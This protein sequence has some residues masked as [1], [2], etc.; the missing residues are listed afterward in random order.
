MLKKKLI[1]ALKKAG[2][3]EGLADL[4]NITSEDQI[5]GVV[6]QLKQTQNNDESVLDFEKILRSE[7]FENYVQKNGFDKVLGLSKTLQ[8]EHDRKVTKGIATGLDN[9]L[10]KKDNNQQEGEQQTNSETKAKTPDYVQMIFDRLDKIENSKKELEFTEKVENALKNSSLPDNLKT[11][12]VSR[13]SQGNTSIEDQ[14]KTLEKEHQETY[15][16]YIDSNIGDGLPNGGS[17]NK[18]MSEEE[19]AEIFG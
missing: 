1:E 8:S 11:S 17:F 7:N 9:F 2:L 15:K 4:I 14:V 13:I 6:N 10:K 18:E 19:I 16:Q 3:K 5:E 12:W